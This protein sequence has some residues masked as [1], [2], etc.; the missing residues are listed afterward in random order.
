[1]IFGDYLL[2]VS[3]FGIVGVIVVN[4]YDGFFYFIGFLVVW[5]VVFLLVVELLC[6]IGWFMMVDVL[7]FWF[8]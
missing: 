7:L 1:V 6:N 5:L 4:G 8:K 2:V 3:F